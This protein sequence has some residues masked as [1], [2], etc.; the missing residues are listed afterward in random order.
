MFRFHWTRFTKP[1]FSRLK[2]S[3]WPFVLNLCLS[4]TPPSLADTWTGAMKHAQMPCMVA[5]DTP[6]SLCLCCPSAGAQPEGPWKSKKRRRLNLSA[7]SS[8]Q[9]RELRALSCLQLLRA[10]L[11]MGRRGLGR[12]QEP[13]LFGRRLLLQAGA[14][15]LHHCCEVCSWQGAGRQPCLHSLPVQRA[16][17]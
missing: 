4:G 15:V 3:L 13:E 10:A 8:H 9:E 2:K 6:E 14:D 5:S 16:P 11:S 7:G 17:C 1:T 12:R